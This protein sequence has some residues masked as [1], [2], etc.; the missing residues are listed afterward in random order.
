MNVFSKKITESYHCLTCG[1]TIYLCV[2]PSLILNLFSLPTV[3][4]SGVRLQKIKNR[5]YPILMLIKNQTPFYFFFTPLYVY[6]CFCSHI[7][8]CLNCVDALGTVECREKTMEG[9]E[10]FVLHVRKCQLF[11]RKWKYG[12]MVEYPIPAVTCNLT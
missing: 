6:V 2:S 10:I 1:Y 12:R 9:M 7:I 8:N 11:C 4:F 3:L 5:I